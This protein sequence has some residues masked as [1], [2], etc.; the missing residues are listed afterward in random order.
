MSFWSTEFMN[1]RRKQWLAALVKFQFRVGSTW[2]D[3]V[4]NTK[5][6]VGNRVEIIVSFPRTSSGSQ[7]ITAVRIIDVT[8]KQ[9]GFQETEVVRASSQGVLTKFELPIYE[10]EGEK[11][12]DMDF[13]EDEV[14]KTTTEKKT[15]SKLDV[16]R[17]RMKK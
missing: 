13:M 11:L 12:S 10:K 1:D 3:A 4:I 5:R 2:H 16:L 6:I 14:P 17:K 7:T 8:G 15:S 9:C